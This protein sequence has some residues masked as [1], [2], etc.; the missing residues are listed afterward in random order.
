LKRLKKPICFLENGATSHEKSMNIVGP[1][2]IAYLKDPL[3]IVSCLIYNPDLK[4]L[5]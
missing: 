3:K 5:E 4:L 1:P 2:M